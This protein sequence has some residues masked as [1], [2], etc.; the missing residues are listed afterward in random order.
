VSAAARAQRTH[1]RRLE[2]RHCLLERLVAPIQLLVLLLAL[3]ALRLAR[4]LRRLRFRRRRAGDELDS[5]RVGALLPAQIVYDELGR[6]RRNA[7]LLEL[8]AQSLHLRLDL[9]M[10]CL[11]LGPLTL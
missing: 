9:L 3:V 8:L 4:F 11:R 7:V 10:L 5:H 2:R 1:R 6:G